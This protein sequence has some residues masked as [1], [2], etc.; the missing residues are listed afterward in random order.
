MDFGERIL[1][2]LKQLPRG[3]YMIVAICHW[4]SYCWLKRLA[5]E[6][7]EGVASFL[8]EEVFHNI[9]EIRAS[10]GGGCKESEETRQRRRELP[11]QP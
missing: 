8:E 3:G 5:T 11:C 1:V 2:D 7:V 10:W 6:H 9:K 4:S